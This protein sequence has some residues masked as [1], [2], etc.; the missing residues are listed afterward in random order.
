[1][2]IS[3]RTL[4][5]VARLYIGSYL[6]PPDW[7]GFNFWTRYFEEQTR[8]LND[9]SRKEKLQE[10]AEGFLFDNEGNPQEETRAE[11]PEL[12]SEEPLT[13]EERESLLV[14]LYKNLFNRE[15]EQ[16]DDEGFDFWDGYLE[17]EGADALG[18]IIQDLIS[19]A[20]DVLEE[21][22]PRYDPAVA[23]QKQKDREIL[24][25]KVDLA[26]HWARQAEFYSHVNYDETPAMETLAGELMEGVDSA[27]QANLKFPRI[28]EYFEKLPPPPLK[29]DLLAGLSKDGAGNKIDSIDPVAASDAEADDRVSLRNH[30]LIR[31]DE[32]RDDARFAG[33]D[34]SGMTVAVLDSGIDLDHPAFGDRLVYS[35]NFTGVGAKSGDD[36]V[37]G[38][39]SDGHGTHVA[40]I[41]TSELPHVSGEG[42]MGIA[43]GANVVG[44]QV[45]LA[46]GG[47]T[48]TAIEDALAFLVAHAE[49]LNLVAINMSL[50]S[51]E[52]ENAN[53]ERA[54]AYEALSDEFE[55]LA[56]LGVVTVL[57]TGN[58]YAEFAKPRG[59]EGVDAMAADPHV[60][61]VGAVYDDRSYKS[62]APRSDYPGTPWI[63]RTTREDAITPFS[64]RSD[65]LK[66]IF[67]P[68]AFIDGA[69]MGG[70][71]EARSGTSQAAPHVTGAVVL[72]QQ[73]AETKLGRRLDPQEMHN[74]LLR[75]GSAI[76]DGDDEDDDVGN[77]S[78][79][80]FR[81]DVMELGEAILQ[82]AE[83]EGPVVPPEAQEIGSIG[84][85][86]SVL[87]TLSRPHERD[88]FEI[89]FD[90]GEA[91]E[92]K[93]TGDG[94]ASEAL[95]DPVVALFG[96]DGK[97]LNSND[98]QDLTTQRLDSLLKTGEIETSGR[99]TVIVSGFGENTGDYV[100]TIS[101]ADGTTESDV[102]DLPGPNVPSV[103]M[104]GAVG[105]T[106]D[107]SAD[108]D[109]YAV[110]LEAGVDY[111]FDLT[112]VSLGDPDLRLLDAAGIVL[113]RNDD[114]PAAPDAQIVYTPDVGGIYYLDAR[115]I[116]S[117]GSY[118]LS[119]AEQ[120]S[121]ADDAGNSASTATSVAAG[122]GAFE[123]T[124][125]SVGDTDWFAL[126]VAAGTRYAVAL[127]TRGA[128]GL[129]DPVLS[130]TAPSGEQIVN[131]DSS[132][133]RNAR[134]EL[135][136]TEDGT[137]RIEARGFSNT[138]LGGYTLSWITIGSVARPDIAADISTDAALAPGETV[139][140]LIDRPG[141]RDWYALEVT[142]GAAYE[143]RLEPTG[144]DDPLFD[145]A[146][147]LHDATGALLVS[148][149]AKAGPAP[150]VLEYAA[151]AFGTVYISAA[152]ANADTDAG[153]YRLSVTEIA[154][155]DDFAGDATT[156][157]T[158]LEDGGT[159]AGRLETTGDRDWF[160]IEAVAGTRYRFDLTGGNGDGELADPLLRLLSADGTLLALNDDDGASLD[161]R[162]EYT[163]NEDGR[164]F[165][166]AAA[167]D[168]F[169]T[170]SYE[171]RSTVIA[172]DVVI[173]PGTDDVAGDVSTD[174][175]IAVGESVVGDLS[176][177]GDVDWFSLSAVDGQTYLLRLS[178]I[179]NEPVQ[180]PNLTVRYPGLGSEPF[181]VPD[182]EG[183]TTLAFTSRKT[184]EIYIEVTAESASDTGGYQLNV[185]S[186]SPVGDD[187][188]D[189]ATT[190]GAVASEGSIDGHLEGYGDA[191]WFAVSVA[192]GTIYTFTLD[193]TSEH[194]RLDEGILGL[195][196]ADGSLLDET[197]TGA[198]TDLTYAAE[199]SGTLFLSVRGDDDFGY[200]TVSS[201]KT[202][203]IGGGNNSA[204]VFLDVP[205]DVAD[206]TFLPAPGWSSDPV[207]V[208]DSANAAQFGDLLTV[209]ENGNIVVSHYDYDATQYF[210]RD[211]R[212]V[213]VS[214]FSPEGAPLADRPILDER[215]PDD[216]FTHAADI[217]ALSDGGFAAIWDS[218]TYAPPAGWTYFVEV[219]NFDA[220]GTPVGGRETLFEYGSASGSRDDTVTL[221]TGEIVSAYT[222]LQAVSGPFSNN[223]DT[224]VAIASTDGSPPTI[225]D[226]EVGSANSG[227]AQLTPIE[228]G[229][230]LAS[231]SETD[232]E[233]MT[234]NY[235]Q[236]FNADGTAA[237]A[238]NE[239]TTTLSGDYAVASF[240]TGGFLIV[241]ETTSSFQI[242]YLDE[243]GASTGFVRPIDPLNEAGGRLTAWTI[244]AVGIGGSNAAILF[245]LGGVPN[246]SEYLVIVDD[247][248]NT[249]G[250][251][252]FVG[253]R[254]IGYAPQIA[255]A[256]DG[257]IT[258]LYQGSG[259]DTSFK[260]E[261]VV[262]ADQASV[263]T[264]TVTEL[265]DGAPAEGNAALT[266]G[267]TL[268][269][270]DLNAFDQ[271]V[272]GVSPH[273]DGAGYLGSLTLSARSG[274]DAST[275]GTVNWFFEVSD[276]DLD[277]LDAGDIAV[278]R[279]DVIVTDDSGASATET[280]TVSLVGQSD[281]GFGDI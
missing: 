274:T 182:G 236:I 87:G 59:V 167:Y 150:E 177:E 137:A 172:R 211:N 66:T 188:A 158:L 270:E 129:D 19:G 60:I 244:D 262:L 275:I 109:V 186:P 97:F 239:I 159:V 213:F 98:D 216:W 108:A 201:A 23:E 200:Y 281:S 260:L 259:Q 46:E 252:Y 261:S 131:D 81:L 91:F 10:L 266:T 276:A 197:E 212:E 39:R 151:P 83:E 189:D 56:R 171:L 55:A 238:R 194:D 165:L 126:P 113:D 164:L 138:D 170:G 57:S 267:G 86:G 24:N 251:P 142:G 232:L 272:A 121:G 144:T 41:I 153:E 54:G 28:D 147:A 217:V 43:P 15:R 128:A 105:G 124:I 84:K 75:S 29:P 44:F 103:P 9:R 104:G 231:W 149:S 96:P 237:S 125:D 5:D 120:T 183:T 233:Q 218:Y 40:S 61:S 254:D 117:T 99:H 192:A 175:M 228:G 257:Q 241:R 127:E 227:Q 68:G 139:E 253:D 157:G 82:L 180:G 162:L 107:R 269:F 21:S 35:W 37:T 210:G 229:R 163:V 273:D 45:R 32:F 63:A 73:L 278:Q 4:E 50:G 93:L 166:S 112:G 8:G 69:A 62:H 110:T 115:G 12:F 271:H 143:I 26:L 90:R 116:V 17:R 58:E 52:P 185:I 265:P 119:A 168:P 47:G 146:L 193:G 3:N 268:V 256:P 280:V 13:E 246:A 22:D 220:A 219:Q 38:E 203:T 198:L 111:V 11:Y 67:A 160:A 224:R 136:A 33:I 225:I 135:T 76:V 161:S 14:K 49:A 214:V 53:T 123:G 118:R 102:P 141:D 191:D 223:Y 243:A 94:A 205:P 152:S 80:F 20:Y 89:E 25:Y 106:I 34:G 18:S 230:F 206:L 7:L 174:A 72:A 235:T 30:E 70:G 196:L 51:G 155:G 199:E 77:T 176:G 221:D 249:L 202:G 64:Q 148:R 190:T 250:D 74:L 277:K 234:S 247:E 263:T 140:G 78:Q 255:S 154:P 36:P 264:G 195:Y 169:A 6:R 100:L 178:G 1:M 204:P 181:D 184:G 242:E 27:R 215:G 114:G 156:E 92:I 279:Y 65:S 258:V 248:G 130:L 132:G 122:D 209:L 222:Q 2:D 134:L 173:D 133:S 71:T 187:F 101:P 179:G 48:A 42:A 226:L 88:V 207:T 245:S 208:T 95:A 31:L 79:T 145:P 240:G 16:I 85:I